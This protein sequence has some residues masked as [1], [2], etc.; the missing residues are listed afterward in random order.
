MAY[1]EKVAVAEAVGAVEPAPT[2]RRRKKI[3]KE[4]AFGLITVLIPLI[5]FVVFSG[6]P[7]VISFIVMFC[8]MD[9]YNLGSIAWNNFATF[10]KVFTDDVFYRSL[11]VTLWVASAQFV[12]LAI[13][14]LMSV[15]LSKKVFG[16][17]VFQILFFVPYVCSS[18]AVSIMWMWMFNDS[19]GIINDLLVRMFG[20]GARVQWFND[21]SVYT[22]MIFIVTVWQA[23]GYGIVMYKAALGSVDPALY[24]AAQMDGA[25]A[26]TQFYKITLPSIAPTT[27]YLLMAGVIAGLLSFDIPKLFSPLDWTGEAGP[28]N[29]GLTTVLYVYIRGMTYHDMPA[30]S[31]MSWVMFV[32]TFIASFIMFKMRN[33]KER[34]A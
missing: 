29:M 32:I 18:I 21:P 31:V 4:A 3:N 5:G 12:S 24:E 8:D 30:A 26:W 10:Q 25:N 14:L 1:Q 28:D 9:Y 7:I 20:E 19:F 13:S 17:K 23:P 15:L 22:W 27:F 33:R 6:F 16:S 11:L 2:A 34:E